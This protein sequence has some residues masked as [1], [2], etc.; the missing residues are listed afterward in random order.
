MKPWPIGAAQAALPRLCF[1]QQLLWKGL[2]HGSTSA[3]AVSA[4]TAT[5]RQL[6]RCLDP[7]GTSIGISFF[8]PGTKAGGGAAA[9]PA[10]HGMSELLGSTAQQ[11]VASIVG[12]LPWVLQHRHDAA[13]RALV[14][15]LAVRGSCTPCY[16]NLDSR[17][18]GTPPL[19][20]AACDPSAPQSDGALGP[21]EPKACSVIVYTVS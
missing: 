11:V 7:A 18:P 15:P 21:E 4:L 13:H 9:A 2:L 16:C 20:T 1:V 14:C 19:L 6:T 3:L 10:V 17:A 8:D 12:G 5:L